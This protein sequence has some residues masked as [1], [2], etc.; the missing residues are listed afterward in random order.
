MSVRSML[1]DEIW[2]HISSVLTT[3]KPKV[4]WP[5][6]KM[7]VCSL[8]S[9]YTFLGIPWRDLPPEL[10]NWSAVYNQLKR[11]KNNGTHHLL[12]FKPY[13]QKGVVPSK[14]LGLIPFRAKY[15][16]LSL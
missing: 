2:N 8:K 1:T 14:V 6:N 16:I 3:I 12:H 7:T 5:Q 13:N 9:F 11:W 10:G 4:G 15:P